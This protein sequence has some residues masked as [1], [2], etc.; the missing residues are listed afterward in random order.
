MFKA[1]KAKFSW[2]M[3]IIVS[4]LWRPGEVGGGGGGCLSL[5]PPEASEA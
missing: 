2:S 1:I 5:D 4:R 3:K